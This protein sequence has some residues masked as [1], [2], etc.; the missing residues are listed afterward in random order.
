MLA[1]IFRTALSFHQLLGFE[2]IEQSGD[3]WGLLDH[4]IGHIERRNPCRTS[5]PEDAQHVELLKCDV[6]ASY[7][8]S[9]TAAD[10]VSRVEDGDRR[11]LPERLERSALPKCAL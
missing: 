8:F 10:D 9:Q 3:P 6:L 2:P 11:F 7:H 1:P 4:T 5:A